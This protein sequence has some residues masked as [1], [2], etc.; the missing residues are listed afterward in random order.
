MNIFSRELKDNR[1]SLVIWSAALSLLAVMFLSLF[2]SFTKDI[3]ASQTIIENLP[4][5]LREALGIS[6]ANFFTIFGFFGY[7]FTF[8]SV[9]G[10]IQA[11]NLGTAII[12]KETG[13]KTIDF[14]LSK[15]INRSAMITQKMLAALCC[16]GITNAV[17]IVSTYATAKAV[18]PAAFDTATFL[19][20]AF[21][22]FLIQLV[23]LCLGL[24]VAVIVPK[25]KSLI[26]VSLPVVFAFFVVGSVGNIID[27]EMIKYVTPFKFYEPDY[28]IANRH[29]EPQLVFIE[30]AIIAIAILI[31]YAIFNRK[32]I[33]PAT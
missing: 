7:L 10:A 23:F 27:K 32:D 18:S 9:A 3:E 22:L 29:Y 30:A 5:A 16:L 14:L 24:A 11:M 15:P 1:R 25:I 19:L 20:I 28:I 8:V 17:F 2:P 26:S 13:G 6:L 31:S 4:P 12:A 21:S 33:R